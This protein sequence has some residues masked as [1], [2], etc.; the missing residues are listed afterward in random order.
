[1]TELVSQLSD[2]SQFPA[3]LQLLLTHIWILTHTSFSL[4][5]DNVPIH[6][7]CNFK[8]TQMTC[9]KCVIWPL[10]KYY[11]II[12][13]PYSCCHTSSGSGLQQ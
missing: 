9:K 11:P 2:E 13:C 12:F 6:E 4:M 7:T 10:L 1:M 5:D 8:I 3:G